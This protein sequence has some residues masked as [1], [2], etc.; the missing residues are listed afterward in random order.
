MQTLSIVLIEDDPGDAGLVRYT[1]KCSQASHSLTWLSRLEELSAHLRKAETAPDII[2]LDLN[3]PDSS[4]MV[5]V[6]DCKAMSRTH[7]SWS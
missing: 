7:R 4:G 5:T 3:L 6:T 1:L 2:L